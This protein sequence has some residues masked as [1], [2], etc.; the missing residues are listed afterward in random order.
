[1]KRLLQVLFLLTLTHCGQQQKPDKETSDKLD[2]VIR[3]GD[4]SMEQPPPSIEYSIGDLKFIFSNLTAPYDLGLYQ[5]FEAKLEY[6]TQVTIQ[7]RTLE[8]EGQNFELTPDY[9]FITDSVSFYLITANNRPE[10]NYFYILKRT[11]LKVE[12]VGQTEPLTKEIFGDV[13]NDGYLEIGG[14]NTHCQIATKED[15]KD[16]DFCLD[17]FR[18]LEINN[19]INRDEETEEKERNNVRQQ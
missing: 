1:M 5:R 7:S 9:V 6:S 11:G 2:D 12:L 4:P 13:D 8:L 14:F 10:P 18:V 15:L 16:P 19:G 3:E 17:H